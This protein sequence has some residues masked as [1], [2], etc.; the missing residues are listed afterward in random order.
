[1]NRDEAI[2]VINEL[3][4]NCVKMEEVYM[5][6]VPPT[7]STPIITHGYQVHLKV[8]YPFDEVTEKC[9]EVITKKYQLSAQEIKAEEKMVIF[10][11][12]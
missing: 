9:I 7:G 1:M 4:E 8:T 3:L 10:R 12:H 5:C 6:M 2:L 11:K